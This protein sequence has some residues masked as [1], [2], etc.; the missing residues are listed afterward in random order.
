MNN[1]R[2]HNLKQ[3]KPR[4]SLVVQWLELSGST[5]R[6]QVQ[7]LVGEPGSHLVLAGGR[8]EGWCGFTLHVLAKHVKMYFLMQGNFNFHLRKN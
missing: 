3:M 5:A 7:S 2:S 1:K 6:A 4:N 8:G